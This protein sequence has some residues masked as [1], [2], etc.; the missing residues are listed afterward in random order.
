MWDG[1]VLV[2]NHSFVDMMEFRYS[3]RLTD[4]KLVCIRSVQS[5]RYK[6]KTR[7]RPKFSFLIS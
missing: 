3:I 5:G 1:V 4:T 7:A 2:I 6:Q